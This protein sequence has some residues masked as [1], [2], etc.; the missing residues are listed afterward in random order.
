[1]AKKTNSTST[2]SSYWCPPTELMSNGVGEPVACVATTFEFH[3]DFFKTELVPRFLGLKFDH[4]EN[5][6]TFLVEREEKLR[7]TDIAVLVDLSR[8]DPRQTTLSWDQIPIAVPG[9]RAIQ[10]AKV[11]L[12]IWERLIR[13]IVGSANLTRDGYR[14]NREVFAALDFWDDPE[15][16]PRAPLDGAINLLER[17]LGWSRVPGGTR[18]RILNS[19]AHVRTSSAGWTRLPADFRP[20][21]KPRVSFVATCPSSAGAGAASAID[22]IITEWGTRR[23]TELAVFTPFVGEPSGNGDTVVERLASLRRSR[24]CIGWLVLPRCP[25]DE[26]D[27]TVRVPFPQSF[28]GAWKKMV[29]SR[30]GERVIALPLHV[31]GVDKVNRPLHSKLISLEDAERHLLM[32]GSSNF[33]PHGMGVGVF[34]VEA[35]VLFED[36]GGAMWRRIEMPVAWE[37]W[38]SAE[39]V[40]W[41][42]DYVLAEDTIDKACLLPRFFAWASY[43]QVSGILRLR[44]D[45]T[46]PQPSA[47]SVRLKGAEADELRLFDHATTVSSDELSFT[48]SEDQRAASLSSLMVEW[49]D[50][51]DQVRQARLIV[52][53]ESKDDLV[54][55]ELFK[56]FGVDAMIECLIR[57]QSLAEWQERHRDRKGLGPGMNA[58]LDSLRSIDTS[59]YVLY[60]VR[61]F[62]RALTGLCERL[63]MTA[64]LP[65]AMRYRLFKDPLGPLAVA[66]AL[67][68][69]SSSTTTQS[70]VA[71]SQD[72][73]LFLLAELLLIV[74]HATNRLLGQADTKTKKWLAPLV[75]E[76]VADFT[77][78]VSGIRD[79]IGPQL[80]MNMDTY[81]RQVLD[82]AASLVGPLP[83]PKEQ[84]DAY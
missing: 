45:R 55:T 26:S 83:V 68:T 43:S 4:T 59:E 27:E 61:L 76:A 38:V 67:T 20:R 23:V 82:Q 24:E 58:A 71:L 30:G 6:S 33:T 36:T 56:G 47:W 29:G 60:R 44:I 5:E 73:R 9:A 79:G 77:R 74:A 31:N 34:N 39:E 18:Q 72:H 1:M 57:G 84:V 75:H 49:T 41:N 32:I 53:V 37:D 10:H 46:Q 7:E 25:S 15:S 12:L 11:A 70:F 64:L 65:T 80:P 51:E 3:A 63:E 8:V 66:K 78:R 50:S 69:S 22:H 2:L 21:Q 52:S 13:L 17:M 54:P 19:L 42:E 62:G 81:I 35:N 14:K 48:F 40:Q 16:V 28:A